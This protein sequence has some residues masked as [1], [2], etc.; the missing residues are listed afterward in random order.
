MIVASTGLHAAPPMNPPSDT[1]VQKRLT[2]LEEKV[3]EMVLDNATQQDLINDLIKDRDELLARLLCTTGSDAE[4]FT[5][6][7]CNVHIVNGL[8]ATYT[9]NGRGNLIVGY[10]ADPIGGPTVYNR[11]APDG[12]N[13]DGP[14]SQNNREGSHNVVIGD[15]HLYASYGGLVAGKQN[16]LN[17]EYASI[18]GGSGN[19]A[20]ADR[21]SIT[22]GGRNFTDGPG[23]T[24]SGGD[25]NYT[26]LNGVAASILGGWSNRA[27][28]LQTAVSGGME[29][30][31]TGYWSS[32]S[33]GQNNMAIGDYTAIGGGTGC[34]IDSRFAWAV[35][36]RDGVDGN[37]GDLPPSDIE[38]CFLTNSL[39]LTD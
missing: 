34:I 25:Q 3:A 14:L 17:G 33:G 16:I 12:Y 6:T 39:I 5:F 28:D 7:N 8:G 11:Y 23:S 22:G 37:P 29:N 2:E 9:R 27:T 13:P 24:I 1:S 18:T 26:G 19:R 38:H 30:A 36:G 15:G 35:G 20:D 32:V 21:S 10:N 4:N 31:A